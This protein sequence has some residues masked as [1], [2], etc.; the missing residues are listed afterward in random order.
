M[1]RRTGHSD[2]NVLYERLSVERDL[3]TGFSVLFSYFE[4]ALKRC[5]FLKDLPSGVAM[6]DWA[7]FGKE[8]RRNLAASRAEALIKAV[9]YL[10]RN[11]PSLQIV[12]TGALDWQTVPMGTDP[13]PAEILGAVCRVRNNL[14][15]GGKFASGPIAEPG[16]DR[17]LI[18]SCTVILEECI[19][20]HPCVRECFD[21]L[22]QH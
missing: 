20:L 14:F 4:Y 5:G 22:S 19:L 9:E 2:P 7:E 18:E 21:S 12:T 3:V 13:S 16:R 11:P 10:R 1:T 6:A 17:R 15:H 8:I